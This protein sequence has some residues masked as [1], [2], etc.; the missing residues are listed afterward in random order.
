MKLCKTHHFGDVTG[1]E[2]G[3]G[4]IG[5]PYMTTIFYSVGNI[6]V[7]TGLS[8]M[9]KEVLEIVRNK[10]I[11]C[12]LLTHHHEDHSGN[13][14]AI[15]KEKQIPAFGHPKTIEKM[16]DGFNILMYQH[17]I[18]GK[19]EIANILP[20]PPVIETEEFSLIPIHAPGHSKDHTIFFE[21][22]RGWLFCGDL[23]LGSKIKYF[24]A[25]E[26]LTDT[27]NSIREVLKLDF[28][29][30]F[31]AHN[32]REHDGRLALQKKLEYLE[33]FSG[34]IARL[35]KSGISEKEIIKK[36]SK[37]EVHFVKMLTFGNVSLEQMVRKAIQYVNS[38][39]STSCMN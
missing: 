28:E 1:Y 37:N 5:K 3:Y 7:D 10:K 9:R 6:L 17:L 25:D 13:V 29:S 32:P 20:L 2:L 27:F 34:E 22:N 15:M 21:K 19:A 12:V 11:D 18:W 14:A 30:L 26:N 36:M 16:R 35:L 23:Y 4:Y 33:N 8:H 31:C 24:R 38:T 39:S